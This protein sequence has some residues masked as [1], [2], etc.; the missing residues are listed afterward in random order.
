MASMKI[1]E[2]VSVRAPAARVFAFLIDPERVVGCIPGASLDAIE[3]P[4]EFRGNV[5]VRVGPV[6]IAY[7]GQASLSEVDREGLRMK[8]EGEGREQSAAGVVKMAME[9]RV[10]ETD[11][12]SKVSVHAEVE[13]AG[14]LVQFGRGMIQGV[15]KQLFK[16]FGARL[17][18]A[19]EE[20]AAA[21]EAEAGAEVEAASPA[22]TAIPT[23]TPTAPPRG[24]EAAVVTRNDNAVNGLAILFRVLADAIVSFF[25]RIFGRTR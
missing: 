13:L 18:A 8:L 17:A 20:E 19:L 25:R 3:S 10:V 7:L 14:K 4:T 16:E 21:L 23:P 2:T 15:S 11:G 1:E 5:K 22:A 9:S 6:S 12:V 24:P